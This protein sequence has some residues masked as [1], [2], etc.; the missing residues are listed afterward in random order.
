MLSG[1]ILFVSQFD[2]VHTLRPRNFFI[3]RWCYRL[4]SLLS[5]R[6]FSRFRIVGLPALFPRFLLECQLLYDLPVLSQG[7]IFVDD[8]LN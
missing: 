3:D 7:N 1:K 5:W 8:R 4:R 6:I 2:L